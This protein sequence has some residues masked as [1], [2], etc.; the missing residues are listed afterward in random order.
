M[1]DDYVADYRRGLDAVL[2]RA[3]TLL[4]VRLGRPFVWPM[5]TSDLLTLAKALGYTADIHVLNRAYTSGAIKRPKKVGRELVWERREALDLLMHLE[6]LRAWSPGAPLHVHKMT[7]YE[8]AE[9]VQALR[10]ACAPFAEG[11]R[12]RPD[13]AALSPK[14][15]I[16]E[17]IDAETVE[18][19]RWAI[20]CL[21]KRLSIVDAPADVLV[22]EALRLTPEGPDADSR[23]TLG[24]ILLGW[25]NGLSYEPIS[26]HTHKLADLLNSLRS[27]DPKNRFNAGQLLATSFGVGAQ[28]Q[29]MSPEE[30]ELGAGRDVS[31]L[32]ARAVSGDDSAVDDLERALTTNTEEASSTPVEPDPASAILS[33]KARALSDT[34]PLDLL[35]DI[36]RET[37][38]DR[39]RT[40]TEGLFLSIGLR[41]TPDSRR[42]IDTLAKHG[43]A[44]AAGDTDAIDEARQWVERN[45]V[46]ALCEGEA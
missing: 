16:V 7:C 24:A 44:I 30:V 17:A 28:L 15:L 3:Q 27:D 4:R 46:A 29:G 41:A 19:R 22:A 36:E 35:D 14:Q 11:V 5:S 34:E 1:S 10:K 43:D 21:R 6:R 12:L 23:A 20:H 39:R 45:I 40:L 26:I 32:L 2:G 25:V 8:R 42:E 13:Y 9:S 31:N 38:D 33:D 37:D 18:L